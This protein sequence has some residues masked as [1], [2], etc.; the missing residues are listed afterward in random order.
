MNRWVLGVLFVGGVSVISI[1]AVAD[2]FVM[3]KQIGASSGVVPSPYTESVVDDFANETGVNL[4]ASANQTYNAAGSLYMNTS[5]IQLA[6]TAISGGDYPGQPKESAF[7]NNLVTFWGPSQLG[8]ALVDTAYIGLDMTV[9]KQ[10]RQVTVHSHELGSASDYAIQRWTGSS[11]ASEATIDTVP[12][13][14]RTAIVPSNV[15]GTQWRLLCTATT[16]PS[17]GNNPFKELEFYELSPSVNLTLQ[18]NATAATATPYA[19]QI[20]ILHEP[21]DAVT[22]GTDIKA[23]LSCDGGTTFAE[24]TG[25]ANTGTEGVYDLLTGAVPITNCATKSMVWK[26]TTLNTKEQR[27]HRVKYEW[28][29]N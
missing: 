15:G 10:V 14:P 1:L 11:W 25:L 19:G 22:P 12:D 16:V 9:T 5:L 6:G 18:S 4:T 23:F 17:N 7:D 13:T 8:T 28:A 29:S 20:E 24:V 21:I 2:N 3:R 26:L 27:I